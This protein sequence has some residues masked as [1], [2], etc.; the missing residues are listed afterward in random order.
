MLNKLKTPRL[1]NMICVK[2]AREKRCICILPSWCVNKLV[3]ITKLV[4]TKLAILVINLNIS[5]IIQSC[6]SLL[7]RGKLAGLNIFNISSLAHINPHFYTF[8]RIY[9]DIYLSKYIYIY[10]CIFRKKFPLE[11][12]FKTDSL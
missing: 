9:R 1:I 3:Y 6:K 2:I 12:N 4:C 7:R 10:V 11:T 8:D 5:E